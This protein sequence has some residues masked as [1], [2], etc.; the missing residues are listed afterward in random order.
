MSF[1]DKLKWA[2][3]KAVEFDKK[4][5]ETEAK[6]FGEPLDDKVD[7]AIDKT[8]EFCTDR[9]KATKKYIENKMKD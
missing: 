9:Y 1:L 3:R 6:I 7:R 4:V 8:G 2:W 5:T